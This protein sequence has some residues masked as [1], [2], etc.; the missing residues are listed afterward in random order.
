MNNILI[1]KL[2]TALKSSHPLE[3][4]SEIV[5]E[6]DELIKLAEWRIKTLKSGKNLKKHQKELNRISGML[7][8]S[9]YYY[10]LDENNIDKEVRE[11]FREM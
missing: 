11:Y 5:N 4:V 3:M 1:K 8:D 2:K 10:F 7:E 6:Y 9:G